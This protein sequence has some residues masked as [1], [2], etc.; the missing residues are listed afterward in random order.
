[1][2]EVLRLCFVGLIVGILARF[3]YPGA[4]PMG[5]FGTISL[6]LGGS[7]VG[8]LLP[9]LWDRDSRNARFSPAGFGGSI[10]GAFVLILIG[11][12]VL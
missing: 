8:G 12:T 2:G 1:M 11:H 10:L 4:V 6:G 7:L 3:L 5:M 9:R